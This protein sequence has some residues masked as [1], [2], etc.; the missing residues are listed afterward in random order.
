MIR[1]SSKLRGEELTIKKKKKRKKKEIEQGKGK[2]KKK[3][4]KP[5]DSLPDTLLLLIKL[6]KNK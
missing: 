1:K 4:P 2:K 5:H 6:K 3:N